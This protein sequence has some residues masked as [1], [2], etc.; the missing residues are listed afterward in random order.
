MEIHLISK[1][2][3]WKG[4]FLWAHTLVLCVVKGNW[5]FWHPTPQSQVLK[6]LERLE[7]MHYL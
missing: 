2:S 7:E 5:K 6:P 1:E 3:S 4:S